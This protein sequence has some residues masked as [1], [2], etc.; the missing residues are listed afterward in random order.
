MGFETGTGWQRGKCFFD[1]EQWLGRRQIVQVETSKRGVGYNGHAVMSAR[2]KE[3]CPDR[4]QVDASSGR[5]Q[6]RYPQHGNVAAGVARL[7][8]E[9]SSVGARRSVP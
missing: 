5:A 9:V 8:C 2:H 1:A 3:D 4:D 7:P 6:S